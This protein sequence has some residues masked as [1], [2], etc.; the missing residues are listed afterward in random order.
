MSE[1]N[2]L[3]EQYEG[4]FT[5]HWSLVGGTYE[6]CDEIP[7]VT[8]EEYNAMTEEEQDLYEREFWVTD[9]TINDTEYA[10][11]PALIQQQYT[12]VDL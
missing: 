6:Y 4:Y 9:T 1:F 11:L 10:E 3:G 7:T 12:P 5:G 2:E 8:D